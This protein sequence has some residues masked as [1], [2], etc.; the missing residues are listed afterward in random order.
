PH[1]DDGHRRVLPLCAA[2][3]ASRFVPAAGAVA[4]PDA[5]DA[6]YRSSGGRTDR[7][8][9]PPAAAGPG[10]AKSTRQREPHSECT[11]WPG[12]T[13]MPVLSNRCPQTP[14]L[15]TGRPPR[16]DA[17]CVVIHPHPVISRSRLRTARL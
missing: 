7:V 2:P 15:S 5:P 6:P 13:E 17:T 8:G 11:G 14:P 16:A 1:G 12:R 10:R 4:E 9:A 3:G